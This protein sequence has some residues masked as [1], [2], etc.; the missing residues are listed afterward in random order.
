MES[1]IRSKY[2]S[3]RWALEGPIPS[4]PSTLDGASSSPAPE[5][6]APAAASAGPSAQQRQQRQQPVAAAPVSTPTHVSSRSQG[7][8][9]LSSAYT[10]R[11]QSPA[12]VAA[13]APVQA[14]QQAP[15]AAAPASAA[16]DLF[17]LDFHTP[18][19][20][21]TPA[22]Q[23][24]QQQPK[25]DVKQDIMSLFSAP[26]ASTPATASF[27][28][29]NA[30]A[31]AANVWG[32]SAVGA[33]QVMPQSAAVQAQPASMMGTASWGASSAW[34]AP[35]VPQ[36]PTFASNTANVWGAPAAAAPPA[37]PA[38]QA[39]FFNTSDVWGSSGAAAAPAAAP[40]ND[41]FGS[42]AS[43]TTPAAPAKKDDVFGDIW[44]G[45]K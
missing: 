34:G 14:A 6:Q 41:L 2:E 37:V 23:A 9:L 12:P 30:P 25:K 11:N 44:G 36:Q 42:F 13:P 4:D 40:S 39:S 26:P 43:S 32:G 19:P 29:F 31:P 45:F 22:G 10:A 33:T 16:Q 17:S 28:A 8:Q 27:G 15:A 5:Y 38:A 20:S 24:Q 21:A 7:H 3:R 1:F 18:S 35:Q